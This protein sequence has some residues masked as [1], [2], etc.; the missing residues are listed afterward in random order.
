[1]VEGK[2]IASAETVAKAEPR[3]LGDA[4]CHEEAKAIIQTL[5]D[6]HAYPTAESLGDKPGDLEAEQLVD[7]VTCTLEAAEAE[8]LGD[9][10]AMWTPRQ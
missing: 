2:L 7:T 8:T 9:T 3:T 6:T 1:M 5:C 10:L 4:L